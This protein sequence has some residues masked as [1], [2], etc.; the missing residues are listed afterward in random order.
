MT[1]NVKCDL[2]VS[3]HGTV[4]SV[5]TEL[6]IVISD[7]L[8]NAFGDA[9]K[10][11]SIHTNELICQENLSV[12]IDGSLPK[13]DS[14]PIKINLPE[15]PKTMKV[16][17]DGL[18]GAFSEYKPGQPMSEKCRIVNLLCCDPGDDKSDP[19]GS[20]Q[21]DEKTAP[22]PAS[23]WY[24][25][26]EIEPGWRSEQIGAPATP[27][28]PLNAHMYPLATA[29]LE[30]LVQGFAS[31]FKLHSR[32]VGSVLIG[33]FWGI[34]SDGALVPIKNFEYVDFK[35]GH[36]ALL[37]YFAER[38]SEPVWAAETL[39]S[40][41]ADEKIKYRI[42][43]MT[44]PV[45]PDRLTCGKLVRVITTKGLILEG[46]VDSFHWSESEIGPVVKYF[47]PIR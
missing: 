17:I 8:R 14:K 28:N 37:V 5:K 27:E 40:L 41:Q 26:K 44:G 39:C 33:E 1:R 46:R 11:V 29:T 47:Y 19:V 31:K 36:G 42:N 6:L 35:N 15:P 23:G 12:R 16:R 3:V 34:F 32:V 45:Y 22:T 4:G 38:E 13:V 43:P 9:F 25:T 21:P 30:S 18:T 20:M 24:T 7:I 2:T 10:T